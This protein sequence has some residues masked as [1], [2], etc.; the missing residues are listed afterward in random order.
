MYDPAK[1]GLRLEDIPTWM[2]P[3]YRGIDWSLLTVVVLCAVMVVP[4]ATRTG[5]PPTLQAEGEMYRLIEVADNLEAG[6]LYPRWAPSFNYGYGSPIFNHIAPLP[7][8]AGGLYVALIREQPHVALKALLIGSIFALGLGSYGFMR[9]RFGELAG[10]LGT[11]VILMSPYILLTVP[12]LYTDIGLVWAMA[13]FMLTLW[14]LD[15]ALLLAKG[16][17]IM[18]LAGSVALLLLSHTRIS[19]L[20][21]GIALLWGF[22]I[23]TVERPQR[24]WRVACLGVVLGFGIAAFYLL[25][26]LTERSYYTWQ[27]IRSY[28]QAYDTTTLFENPPPLDRSAFNH[29]PNLYLGVATWLLGIFGTLWLAFQAL[30]LR[31]WRQTEWVGAVVFVPVGLLGVWLSY[32]HSS[33]T[34]GFMSPTP[35]ELISIV[36]LACGVLAAQVGVV[37]ER[38][39]VARLRRVMAL[40]ILLTMLCIS[41]ASSVY[42][43]A[44]SPVP[45]PVSSALHFNEELRG[46][47]FGSLHHGY[48]LPASVEELPPPSD[49]LSRELQSL[50]PSTRITVNSPIHTTYEIESANAQ[51]FTILTFDYPGWQIVLND[52]IKHDAVSVDTGLIEVTLEEGLNRLSVKFTNTTVRTISWGLSSVALVLAILFTLVL[53]RRRYDTVPEIVL[54]EAFRQKREFQQLGILATLVL[55]GLL[56]VGRTLP[57]TV[58]RNTPPDRI[59]ATINVLDLLVSGVVQ[60]G[61]SLLGYD[62]S[63]TRVRAGEST[64]VQLYWQPNGVRVDEYQVRFLIFKDGQIMDAPTYRHIAAWP[65]R[66]WPRDQYISGSFE[67]TP[68]SVPGTYQ[69]VL[70]IGVNAC[71]QRQLT[72]C[73]A[74]AMSEIYDLRGPTGQQILLPAPIVVYN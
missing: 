13:A 64:L 69:I 9:R 11:V 70:E 30:L 17:D 10:L 50:P 43:P 28:P 65:V 71:D 39:I 52:T 29:A 48:F 37:L 47:V 45:T 61:V 55:C 62:I 56:V 60:N 40:A 63:T 14:T 46:N 53:E 7:H 35:L 38:Y 21:L 31:Q 73:E 18:L 20:L 16:R 22:I 44:F 6:Q 8:Y 42:T 54:P 67:I 58:T 19:P 33:M 3:T 2:Q 41:A 57:D 72:P 12:Y 24:Y 5:L 26:A 32:G 51:T 59:P 74:M 68:P 23:Y 49:E 34:D 27:P 4:L 25:P 66:R 36:V 1:Y 15:R